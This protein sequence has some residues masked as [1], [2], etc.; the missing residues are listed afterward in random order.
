MEGKAH[1]GEQTANMKLNI[2]NSCNRIQLQSTLYFHCR[3]R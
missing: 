2:L 1:Q 3:I